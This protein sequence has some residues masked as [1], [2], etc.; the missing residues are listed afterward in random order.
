MNIA[1]IGYGKMGQYIEKIAINRNHKISFCS[2]NTPNS[3]SIALKKIDVA[4]EFSTPNSAFNNVK[5][6]IENNIS[7]VCGTTGWLHQIHLIKELCCKKKTFS[8]L[9]S[10]NFSIGMNIVYMI[11]KKLSKLLYHNKYQNYNIE[12]DEIHHKNKKD[13]P[14]GT[15]I[16][17]SQII[18]NNKLKK[19]WTVE[20]SKNDKNNILIRSTRLGNEI[21]THQIKYISKID[22]I[23]IMHKAHSRY[24]FAFGAVIAAEWLKNKNGFFSMEDVLSL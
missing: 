24:C 15:A 10:S 7:V 23:E 5:M 16:Q 18:I 12:I 19:Y 1:I 9:Y 11:N 20:H 3:V 21:G 13:I 2:D 8:F 22:D 17:L 6:C 4:I 14:S